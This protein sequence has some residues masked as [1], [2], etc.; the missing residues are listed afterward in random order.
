MTN[1][2]KALEVATMIIEEF[3][4]LGAAHDRLAKHM[5]DLLAVVL[6]APVAE[7]PAPKTTGK[8]VPKK[9]TVADTPVVNEVEEEAAEDEEEGIDLEA[10][11]LKEL[12][13]LADE[14]DI[15]YPKGVKKAA[16]I[17]I[18]S[19]ALVDGE[20]EEEAEEETVEEAEEEVAEEEEE[21]STVIETEDG[22]VDLAEMN[23]KQLKAFAEE[24]GL[25]VSA[26]KK[27][28]LIAEILEQLYADSEEGE[29]EEPSD[30]ELEEIEEEEEEAEDDGEDVAEQLG[31]NDM[32]VEELAEILSENGL[33]TKGKKQALVDRIVRAI[34]DGTIEVEGED[35]G[36]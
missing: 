2:N 30:E 1:T 8:P 10:L 13:S 11:S 5:E 19:E 15:E 27:D 12:K 35:E 3:K 31:L 25:E 20:N 16:L 22:D 33:S 32:E 7:T 4:I 34:E 6:E 9:E 28:G 14:H 36:E 18:I 21:L 29:E 26:K 24:Y 17:D 23:V